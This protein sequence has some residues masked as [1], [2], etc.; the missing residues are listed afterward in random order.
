MRMERERFHPLASAL[1]QCPC[2]HSQGVLH[3]P[4]AGNSFALERCRGHLEDGHGHCGTVAAGAVARAGT[5]AGLDVNERAKIAAFKA[6]AEAAGF[7]AFVLQ[8][9][10]FGKRS[11]EL[12]TCQL[13]LFY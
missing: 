6:E 10:S 12:T 4:R 11:V 7:A 9:G 13:Q 2:L 5:V 8:V 3:C 1:R